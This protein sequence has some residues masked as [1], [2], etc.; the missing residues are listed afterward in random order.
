MLIYNLDFKNLDF[1]IQLFN[2]VDKHQDLI[3]YSKI[4][5]LYLASHNKINYFPFYKFKLWIEY[6]NRHANTGKNLINLVK[7]QFLIKIFRLIRL[8]VQE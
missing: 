4:F 1:L 2:I 6:I 3:S 8:D 7:D 5:L